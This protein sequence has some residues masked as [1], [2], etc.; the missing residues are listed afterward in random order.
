ME[1]CLCEI[2]QE[3]GV[4][5]KIAPWQ[6]GAKMQGS[7]WLEGASTPVGEW[8]LVRGKRRLT[9]FFEQDQIEK[10]L[11]DWNRVQGSVRL[12]MFGKAQRLEPGATVTVRQYW[13]PGKS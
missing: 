1:Y 13:T 12:E 8:S 11:L 9:V 10:C 6:D 4:V 5:E 7:V 2:L 3:N